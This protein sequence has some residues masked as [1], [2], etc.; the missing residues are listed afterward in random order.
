MQDMIAVLL[1]VIALAAGIWNW[2]VDNGG[3]FA[4]EEKNKTDE[5]EECRD[6]KN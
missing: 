1:C 4:K 3:T 2:W 6:E 5:C